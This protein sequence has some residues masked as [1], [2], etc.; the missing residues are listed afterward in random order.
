[1]RKRR[2][3]KSENE[4]T[5]LL[6]LKS[7]NKIQFINR[8]ILP[9]RWRVFNKWFKNFFIKYF[10]YFNLHYLLIRVDDFILSLIISS[11]PDQI[12]MG[13]LLRYPFSNK[14]RIIEIGPCGKKAK[15]SR[16]TYLKKKRFRQMIFLT[17]QETFMS[18]IF[19]QY[20]FV[21]IFLS[22]SVNYSPTS[23]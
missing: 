10:I 9:K 17:K 16:W 15:S 14:K 1:M 11:E 21:E 18:K 3:N 4:N 12:N 20:L 22:V 2:V 5:P 23:F 19:C 7:V 6:F 13:P 8:E